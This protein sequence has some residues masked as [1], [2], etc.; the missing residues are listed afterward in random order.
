[1]CTHSHTRTQAHTHTNADWS[2]MAH[3]QTTQGDELYVFKQ[4]SDCE[5]LP[6]PGL[7]VSKDGGVE[8]LQSALNRWPGNAIKYLR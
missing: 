4:T 6:R 8:A 3:V 1:M 2:M 7:S 5:S